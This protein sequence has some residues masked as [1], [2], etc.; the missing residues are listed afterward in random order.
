MRQFNYFYKSYMKNEHGFLNLM[1][2]AKWFHP[3]M[4][5]DETFGETIWRT[6]AR[7]YGTEFIKYFKNKELKFKH[8]VKL[9]FPEI[10]TGVLI[11]GDIGYSY[12]AVGDDEVSID[13]RVVPD[14]NYQEYI[15][16][17]DFIASFDI[18]IIVK[19]KK[20]SIESP[21]K[22][23]CDNIDLYL[24]DQKISLTVHENELLFVPYYMSYQTDNPVEIA[25]S[26]SGTENLTSNTER[27]FGF[28][29]SDETREFLEGIGIKS[30]KLNMHAQEADI[31]KET[32][33]YELLEYG[34]PHSSNLIVKSSDKYIFSLPMSIFP[35]NG[36]LGRAYIPIFDSEKCMPCCVYYP[37][38]G[39]NLLASA[40]FGTHTPTVPHNP[41]SPP[42]CKRP[43]S[44][45]LREDQYTIRNKLV[46][47]MVSLCDMTWEM[48]DEKAKPF[49]VYTTEVK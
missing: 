16:I 29:I 8:R 35:H 2:H 24:F 47:K 48:L 22:V 31:I 6:P 45:C 39:G 3:I 21:V 20:H 43:T 19:F 17:N 27:K 14:A 44:P 40:I 28:I 49:A 33:R 15:E 1:P 23:M 13:Y 7:M 5:M 4:G 18:E 41:P 46:N 11:I 37:L 36:A 25:K 42:P 10:K 32:L 12:Y 38:G 34:K 30:S 26:E 9:F